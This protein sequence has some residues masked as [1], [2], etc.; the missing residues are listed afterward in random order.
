MNWSE[1]SSKLWDAKEILRGDYKLN[2]YRDVILPFVV[3]RRLDGVLAPH[4]EKILKEYEKIK[5]ANEQLIQTKMYEL[6]GLYFY[7]TSQYDLRLLSA[8]PDGV[9]KHLKEYIKGFSKNIRD[10]FDKFEFSKE[11]DKLY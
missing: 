7:N 5:N 11:I 10:V 1:I 3:L 6:T 8:D 4:K 2:Q 9:R